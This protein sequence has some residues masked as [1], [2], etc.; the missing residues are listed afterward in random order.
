[1]D[2]KVSLALFKDTGREGLRYLCTILS[3]VGVNTCTPSVIPTKESYSKL[4]ANQCI[5]TAC[6]L[7]RLVSTVS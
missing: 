6:L 5:H 2:A 4:W 7:C 3:F 1:M